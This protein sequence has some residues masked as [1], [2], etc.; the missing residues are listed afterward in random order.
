ML[1]IKKMGRGSEDYYLNLTSYF[2]AHRQA[3][4]SSRA[5]HQAT[6]SAEAG[7]LAVAIELPGEPAG[8]WMGK[9]A[10]RLGLRNEVFPEDLKPLMLGF[11]SRTGRALVQNAGAPNRVPGWDF[12]FSAPKSV[13]IVWSQADDELRQQIEDVHRRS[14]TAAISLAEEHLAYSRI[15][16][17][18]AGHL[19]V[20]LVVAGFQHGTS[21]NEDAQLHTH[22]LVINV[23]V[24]SKD[25]TRALFSRPFFVNRNMLGAYY[26]AQLAFRLRAMG[27]RLRRHDASFEI[28]GVPEDLLRAC[29]SR[30]NEIL[31]Y[32][33]KQGRSGGLA[34]SVATLDTRRSKAELPPRTELFERWQER[35][36]QFGFHDVRFLMNPERPQRQGT[37]QQAID[38]AIAKLAT[39][40]SHF[41]KTDFL[42]AALQEAPTLGLGPVALMQ[43]AN[44]FLDRVATVRSVTSSTIVDAK[45]PQPLD[46]FDLGSHQGQQRF[47]TREV[48]EEEQELIKTVEKLKGRKGAIVPEQIVEMAIEHRLKVVSDRAQE[49]GEPLAEPPSFSKE[50][51]GAIRHLTQDTLGTGAVRLLRGSAGTGKTDIAIA[52]VKKALEEAGFK[53]IAATPTAKAARILQRATGLKVE[54]ITKT[55]GDYELPWGC[56][57]NHHY[58][59]IKNQLLGKATAPLRK[60][61]PVLLDRNTVLMVDEAGM[62]AT[63]ETLMLAQMVERSGASLLLVGDDGQLPPVTRGAPFHSLSHRLG[64]AELTDIQRQQEGWARQVA[65]L[66]AAGEVPQALQILAEH[67][68]V[69]SCESV[70]K[71][72]VAMVGRWAAL[73]AAREPRQAIMLAN[74][75][76]EC[77]ALNQLAQ[78]RRLAANAI[79]AKRS[80]PIR[81]LDQARG[82][83]FA[84]RVYVGDQILITK[85][86]TGVDVQNGMVGT[87]IGLN[88]VNHNVTVQFPSGG[89]SMIPAKQFSHLRLGY[90]VTTYKAQGDGYPNVLVLATESPQSKPSFYVQMTRAYGTTE[91]FTTRGLWNPDNE[92]IGKSA[93]AEYL[94]RQ[95]D[96][97]L[98]SDLMDV[99]RSRAETVGSKLPPL[100]FSC[101]QSPPAS[102]APDVTPSSTTHV[103]PDFSARPAAPPTVSSAPNAQ[104][105]EL[106]FP[107]PSQ[108]HAPSPTEPADPAAIWE[109]APTKPRRKKKK[110]PIDSP[111]A[112]TQEVLDEEEMPLPPVEATIPQPAAEPRVIVAPELPSVLPAEFLIVPVPSLRQWRPLGSTLSPDRVPLLPQ[113]FLVTPRRPIIRSIPSRAISS[114]S[115]PAND[116]LAKPISL[117]EPQKIPIDEARDPIRRQARREKLLAA[118][119]AQVSKEHGVPPDQVEV[120]N[121]R[122]WEEDLGEVIK[123][124]TEITFLIRT[125]GPLDLIKLIAFPV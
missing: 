49:S 55:L 112:G 38:A 63:R 110:R 75:N 109:P 122:E 79:D 64:C 81:D 67:D 86:S 15:G 118:A 62:V 113:D 74:T 72:A 121:V 120:V 39:E 58:K 32:L 3:R 23:A 13:S 123:L 117:N 68:A 65:K 82:I 125:Y 11:H 44:A 60:P 71:A 85:N 46:L 47:A 53:V 10:T 97:R 54:T 1:S 99:A 18:G 29:S 103:S 22:C 107:P 34:S 40:A 89:A 12:T 93:L 88:T 43:E 69:H 9:G 48:L 21:R 31:A 102:D 115:Q 7:G 25:V 14:V 98:A 114:G 100:E 8:Q 2:I 124:W 45:S 94:S 61:S 106:T 84:S 92:V 24:D 90:A 28:V 51:L 104:F 101:P 33:N 108:Q 5:N 4:L 17:A 50:Q 36:R 56:V 59:Q 78:R 35:N 30:R 91:I 87:V 27:F 80:I 66:A 96:L 52:T 37:F 111:E 83:D 41:S 20:K 42:A 95:P 26:R 105:D 19:P 73:G 76:E 77:E 70:E 16:K 116:R 119:I 6:S 57:L